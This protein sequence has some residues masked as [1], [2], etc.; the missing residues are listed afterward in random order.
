M[1]TQY[2][3]AIALG[4]LAAACAQ[5]APPAGSPASPAPPPPVMAGECDASKAQ[6]AVGRPFSDALLE[7]AR[8][9]TGAKTAR[10]LRPGQAITMEYSFQRLNLEL[11]AN[12]QVTRVRCG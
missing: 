6:Y 10:L 5:P 7:E 12:G 4:S 3:I 9:R 8:T 11:D 2:L 1:N